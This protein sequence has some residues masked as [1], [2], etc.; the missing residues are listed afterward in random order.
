MKAKLVRE[1]ME[2]GSP[3]LK[4]IKGLG[5][6]YSPSYRWVDCFKV[7]DPHGRELQ[8]W[9]RIREAYKYCKEQGWDYEVV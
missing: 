9:M 5:R 6:F 2:I 1:R 3:V 8:P 4:T 7:I